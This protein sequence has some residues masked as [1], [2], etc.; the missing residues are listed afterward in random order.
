VARCVY[1]APVPGLAAE[2]FEDWS[3]KFG[4]LELTDRKDGPTVNV[5]QLVGET[6]SHHESSWRE[7]ESDRQGY[8]LRD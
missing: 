3:R 1:I 2:R 8:G 4:G 6:V 5:V 7:A